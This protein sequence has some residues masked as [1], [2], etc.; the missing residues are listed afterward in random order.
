MSQTITQLK[1]NLAG[2]LHGGT[3]NK[4]RSFEAL[5]E[6]SINTM[7]SKVD[8]VDTIRVAPL[9]NTIH[10]DVYNYALPSD[11]KKI[12][13]LSPQDNRQSQDSASRR[14]AEKFAL[15]SMLASKQISIEGSEGSK[16][17][18]INWK[19]RQ[20]KVLNS[21]NS[22]TSNGT[23]SAVGTT[24]GIVA[25]SIT[26]KT[27]SASIR[28]DL[29]ATGDGIQ[30]TGMTQV[31][32]TDEDEV[33][34]I[35][36]Y[37]YVKDSTDLAKITSITAIWGND[38]STAY[39]TGVAQTTQADG[40]AFQVGW[41][42]VKV[43]W[44]TATETGTVV[45]TTIDSFKI[46]VVVSSALSDM[47]VDNIIFS[48]GRAFDIKYYSKYGVKNS[49]GTWLTRTTSDDDTLVFDNDASQIMILEC[50]IAAAQQ[51]EGSDSTFDIT[52]AKKEL[53]G[54]DLSG[55]KGLYARYKAEFPSQSKKAVNT[56]G[57]LPN[58]S[59]W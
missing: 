4:V 47:R 49:S 44:S 12:I 39:W 3:L 42:L 2:M 57:S 53:L 8:P 40:S 45:P 43:P 10:D 25:D 20:G 27:G 6:R 34:D 32:M 52:W 23:W 13:D 18:R 46:T 29:A 33:A 37:F 17:I 15:A 19:S 31:D 16:I 59:R 58:R 1:E 38:V 5:L 30:N 55:K 26:K 21:M 51:M 48:I 54:E 56:Y 22:V 41:N 28:F 7:L 50:L 35:F 24:S 36:F 9:T 11:F 14:F